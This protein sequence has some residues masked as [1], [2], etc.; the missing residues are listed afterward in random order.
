MGASKIEST[1][2]IMEMGARILA[3]AFELE[4][5]GYRAKAVAADVIRAALAAMSKIQKKV[6]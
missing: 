5:G 4:I 6:T 1:D 3:D 2:A